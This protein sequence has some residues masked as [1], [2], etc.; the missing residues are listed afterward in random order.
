MKS[1]SAKRVRGMNTF[2][3]HPSNPIKIVVRE[4]YVKAWQATR[5]PI[6]VVLRLKLRRDE[7]FSFID[8]TLRQ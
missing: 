5:T 6:Y 1:A 3:C 7:N 2:K 8:A 4:V